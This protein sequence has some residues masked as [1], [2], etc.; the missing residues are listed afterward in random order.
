MR[1]DARRI[2]GQDYGIFRMD[3]EGLMDLN[4]NK[5]WNLVKVLWGFQ[6]YST[7]SLGSMFSL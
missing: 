1:E 4:L 6:A 5:V 3:R 2:F 7:I